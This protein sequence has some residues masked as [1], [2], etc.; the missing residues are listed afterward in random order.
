M[1]ILLP[2][3]FGLV[4]GFVNAKI[5]FVGSAFSLIPWAIVGAFVG[6]LTNK[7]KDAVLSGALY[8]FVLSVVFIISGYNGTRP[9]I[10]VMPF[11]ILLGLFGAV[12][13]L[14]L[15]LV[16]YLLKLLLKK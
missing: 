1:N 2:V 9:L 11:F 7:K 3:I 10:A 6:F 4:L 14:V 8:G 15:G 5:L 13:G 16:G 12:C